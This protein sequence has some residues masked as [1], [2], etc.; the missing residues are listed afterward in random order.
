MSCKNRIQNHAQQQNP[1]KRRATTFNML[2]ESPGFCIHIRTKHV[3][4]TINTATTGNK[5]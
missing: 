1:A 5:L 3:A 2:N 4:I